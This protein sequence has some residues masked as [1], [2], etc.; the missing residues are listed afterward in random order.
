MQLAEGI[1]CRCCLLSTFCGVISGSWSRTPADDDLN[2]IST[3]RL[4][5]DRHCSFPAKGD[6]SQFSIL[7]DRLDHH[8]CLGMVTFLHNLGYSDELSLVQALSKCRVPEAEL[9]GVRLEIS[10][11]MLS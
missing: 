2:L 4:G 1:W 7:I 8:L 3:S 11:L 5:R 10:M 6:L 9:S